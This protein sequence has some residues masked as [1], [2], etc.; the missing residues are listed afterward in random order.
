MSDALSQRRRDVLVHSSNSMLVYTVSKAE[1]QPTLTRLAKI[2]ASFA[3][4]AVV[5][6]DTPAHTHTM[7]PSRGLQAVRG[8]APRLYQQQC[9]NVSGHLRAPTASQ[10]TPSPPA[11]IANSPPSLDS[12]L[13]SHINYLVAM[14]DTN[15]RRCPL[16][17][18]HPPCF[19]SAH[20]RPYISAYSASR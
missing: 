13:L 2:M 18:S 14:E 9:R 4:A 5:Y 19:H 6:V 11:L 20:V 17:F 1:A 16:P 7:M 8:S 15:S 3:E 10:L 12:R